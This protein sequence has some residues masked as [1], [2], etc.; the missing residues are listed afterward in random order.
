MEDNRQILR[1]LEVRVENGVRHVN[2]GKLLVYADDLVVATKER[3]AV[4]IVWVERPDIRT[5]DRVVTFRTEEEARNVTFLG[6][7]LGDA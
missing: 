3:S 6:V 7:K 1:N 2:R 5:D 4:R